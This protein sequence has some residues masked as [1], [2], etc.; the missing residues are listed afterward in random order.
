M[1]PL[2]GFL[3]FVLGVPSA[4]A[5]LLS[6]SGVFL[7]DGSGASRATYSNSERLSM[8]ARLNNAVASVNRVQ[9]KFRIL[10]PV[11]AEVF[12]HTGN[13]V[14]G[15][16]GN[17][18][19]QVSGIPIAKFFTGPG[20][21]TF[22]ADATLDGQTVSQSAQFTVSSPN[23]IMVY[24]PN[25]ARDVSDK[26]LSLRWVSSGAAKYRVTVGDNASL[27]N[28]VFSG[29]TAG[30]ENFLNYPENPADQRAN[31]ASGQVYYWKV[32]G[33][34][35]DGNVVARSEV[36]FNFTARTASLTRDMAVATLETTGLVGAEVFFRVQV[37][38]QGGTSE[39]NVPLRLSL[40]GLPASGSPISLP[41]LSAGDIKEYSFS[42][43]IPMD[44][45]Q[46]LAIACVEFFDD[47]VPN[48]CK[49][50]QVQRPAT[51]SGSG[52]GPARP[53]TKEELW[54]AL[55]Q[56]LIEQGLDLAGYD[57]ESMSQ[58]ST[59]DMAALL[60]ELSKGQVTIGVSGP[61]VDGAPPIAYV[62]PPLTGGGGTD[63]EHDPNGGGFTAPLDLPGA[64]TDETLAASSGPGSSGPGASAGS[65]D[66][67]KL[68]S[69]LD[70]QLRARGLDL[71]EYDITD[72]DEQLSA[73]DQQAFYDALESG[74]IDM[75]VT[76]PPPGQGMAGGGG[77]ADTGPTEPLPQFAEPVTFEEP[78]AYEAAA[79]T[80][81]AGSAGAPK[82]AAPAVRTSARGFSGQ[83][84]E[85][86]GKRGLNTVMRDAK[87]FAK[88]WKRMSNGKAPEIDFGADMVVVVVAGTKRGAERVEFERVAEAPDGL[89][90]VYRASGK[91]ALKGTA[92]FAAVVIR[93]SNLKAEFKD[94]EEGR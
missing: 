58:L 26:P 43:P 77:S 75:K 54:Q 3:A 11:G 50:L 9:F 94:A 84:V 16:A 33:L 13:S 29:L 66:S 49:S 35:N 73:E 46:S 70:E 32:E 59:E 48:N 60:A 2:A 80:A 34:D 61:P 19:S 23:I 76:G 1:S 22:L 14:P 90:V 15:S 86:F 7:K 78:A 81:A 93:Q 18:A 17:S 52:F 89:K 67:Q 36:P 10:N 37:R 82:A 41:Q 6:A 39:A 57:I 79:S 55:Q 42:A 88:L 4:Q 45:A 20:I 65:L 24:P 87:E 27:Y 64:G 38:N 12:V 40:G 85:N 62:P 47:N 68:W 63:W 5:G 44:Q 28:S 30:G 56:K 53:L 74:D 69:T 71:R 51:G 83:T 8:T 25:G 31:L 72:L 91:G 92:P 21:Y